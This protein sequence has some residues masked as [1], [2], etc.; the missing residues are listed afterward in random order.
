MSLKA[1]PESTHVTRTWPPSSGN[2]RP[3]LRPTDH[4]ANRTPSCL[5]G[6]RRSLVR[7]CSRSR[8][9][10]RSG[11]H[12]HRIPGPRST[13]GTQG[14]WGSSLDNRRSLFWSDRRSEYSPSPERSRKRWR[15]QQ[16]SVTGPAI[17]PTAKSLP[18]AARHDELASHICSQRHR[19]SAAASA[20]RCPNRSCCHL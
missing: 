11:A 16:V 13:V 1:R 6:L 14:R 7:R 17:G 5:V 19:T 4:A 18:A 2:H 10:Y 3:R 12:R 9:L 15:N 8:R 20:C